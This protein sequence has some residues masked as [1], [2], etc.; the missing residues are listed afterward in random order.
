MPKHAE[1]IVKEMR[2]LEPREQEALR[3]ICRKLG[4][5]GEEVCA[6]RRKKAPGQN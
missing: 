5:G 6:E 3:R 2:A 1:A 4:K